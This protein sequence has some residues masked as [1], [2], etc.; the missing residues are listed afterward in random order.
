MR[1][2]TFPSVY[3]AMSAEKI[4]KSKKYKVKLIPVPRALTASCEGLAAEIEE[5]YLE[6]I[7]NLLE[8]NNIVMLK[9]GIKV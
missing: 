3:H 8:E 4:L 9:K 5:D 2:I 7:I 6:E 1:I